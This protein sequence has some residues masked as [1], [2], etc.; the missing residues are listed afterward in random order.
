[1]HALTRMAHE[2]WSSL[3]LHWRCEIQLLV[4][5]SLDESVAPTTFDD[6][7][8]KSRLSAVTEVLLSRTSALLS[9]TTPLHTHLT[10]KHLLPRKFG[11]LVGLGIGIHIALEPA[12]NGLG[13]HDGETRDAEPVEPVHEPAHGATVAKDVRVFL[14]LV[15]Q[16]L[17]VDLECRLGLE[18]AA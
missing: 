14:K 9:T 16:S 5:I 1:M 18:G 2:A 7:V 15:R 10:D 13:L 12:S 6:V 17:R 4:V 8:G 3:Q 11:P